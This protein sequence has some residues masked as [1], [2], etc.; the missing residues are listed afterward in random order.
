MEKL[1]ELLV[2]AN[3][4]NTLRYA[5]EYGADAVYIGGKNFNLRS[6][7]QN[8]TVSQIRQAVEYAHKKNC[9]IYLTVNAVVF[10]S[11]LLELKEYLEELKSISLDA[12]IISDIGVMEMMRKINN[13]A[14]IHISTQS[15]VSNHLGV[16]FFASMGASRVNIAREISF[17][18]LKKII[19]RSKIEIEV[20]AH[21]ALCIS[22]SGRCMLSKYMSGRDA[23]KGQCAHSC[24]WKYHL[25]EESRPN[26]FYN[27]TQDDKGTYIYNSRD[28]CLLEKMD[29]LVEAGVSSIKIEGR[30]KTENY[31]SQITWAYRKALDFI[32]DGNFSEDKKQYLIDE[33]KKTTH[34]NFTIGFMFL[35][36]Y[37][38][39]EE[40]NDVR[41][42]KNYRFVGVVEN[43]MIRVKNQ[44]KKG[45]TLEI[46]QPSSLPFSIQIEEIEILKKGEFISSP[47]ANPNDVIKIKNLEDLNQY[48]I[49]RIKSS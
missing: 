8:F 9:R 48:A 20:F 38:E 28:L 24:R 41:Y 21:G 3:N 46:L 12:Y 17:E 13:K 49:L 4:L 44:F 36:D 47:V 23:N 37:K 5:I 34:R 35:D 32:R 40:N 10:E 31:V 19:A 33:I 43:D 6:L 18:D 39:L 29:Q 25:L 22:Y 15:N 27:I 30:M 16:D 11:E 26:L 14:K 7:G 2:P 45:E 42:I 1:P